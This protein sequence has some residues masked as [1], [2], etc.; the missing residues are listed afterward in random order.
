MIIGLWKINSVPVP[1]P[2]R[3]AY[4]ELV[5]P[6]SRLDTVALRQGVRGMEWRYTALPPEEFAQ[7]ESIYY[8]N[9]NKSVLVDW[10]SDYDGWQ[11]GHWMMQEPTI[12]KRQTMNF[13]GVVIVF[14]PIYRTESAAAPSIS[15]SSVGNEIRFLSDLVVP[16]S[17]VR[18]KSIGTFRIVN[19]AVGAPIQPISPDP[20]RDIGVGSIT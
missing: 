6:G 20:G 15:A 13:T 9:E 16:E 2:D 3:I 14:S 18:T 17:F 11:T 10:F 5:S 7:L 19:G 4:R 1:G 12:G 8:A